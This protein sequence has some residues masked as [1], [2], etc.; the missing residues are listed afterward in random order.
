MKKFILLF[1][2]VALLAAC[3]GQQKTAQKGNIELIFATTTQDGTHW[4]QTWKVMQ[5]YVEEQSKGRL[6]VTISFGGALGN[7]TQLLQ[8]VQVGSQV[9]MAVS[10]GANLA[11]IV[12]V[13]KSFDI[14]FF[15][16]NSQAPVDL[17]FPGGKFGGPIA[18]G[19][20]PFFKEK[21]LRLYGVVP[22]ELRG[23]MT[24]KT[25]IRTP[26]DMKGLKIRVT[27]NPVERE[28]MKSMGSG[29]TSMGISEVYTALQ[30]G[31][32][33]GLAIPP[34]TA[35]AFALSE[36]GKEF[37]QLDFQLH[38][39]FIVINNKTWEDLPK[40][41]QQILQEGMNQAIAQTRGRYDEVLTEA[42]D[43]MKSQGVKVHVPSEAEKEAFKK[44]IVQPAINTA[45]A[46]FSDAEKKY[47]EDV[48][49]AAKM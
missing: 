36:V 20:Q 1:P 8:K 26:N 7:D 31:T 19:I 30:T 24:R 2:F 14:P 21:N 46:D 34:I 9:H 35:V 4:A 38:G 29:P 12:N 33:D 37:N 42:I 44:V 10:S 6:K 5:T 45:F 47:Y 23:L 11:S 25:P 22:F 18:D 49:A 16:D 39:S 32:V 43:K 48:S 27:P 15:M 40:D 3:G 28:I 17:F 13:I 41:L